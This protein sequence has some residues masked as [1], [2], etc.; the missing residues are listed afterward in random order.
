MKFVMIIVSIFLFLFYSYISSYLDIPINVTEL[1]FVVLSIK[2][3]L[4]GKYGSKIFK[5]TTLDKGTASKIAVD[6]ARFSVNAG[7]LGTLYGLY[8]VFINAT[9]FGEITV[10]ASVALSPIIYGV[11]IKLYV[12]SPFIEE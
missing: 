2:C 6:G 4:I 8:L 9:T 1:L 11:F 7:L 3:L 5:I 10:G 12:F